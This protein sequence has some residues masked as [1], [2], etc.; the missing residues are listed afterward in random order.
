MCKFRPN[1]AKEIKTIGQILNHHTKYP[2]EPTTYLTLSLIR[3]LVVNIILLVDLFTILF[4]G[5]L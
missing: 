4:A 5:G 3:I 2:C 1:Y